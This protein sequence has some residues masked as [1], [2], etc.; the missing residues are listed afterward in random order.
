MIYIIIIRQCDIQDIQINGQCIVMVFLKRLDSRH[1]YSQ[2]NQIT[3]VY[4]RGRQ[5]V[6]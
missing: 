6:M 5:H 4:E 1:D 3:E 2:R